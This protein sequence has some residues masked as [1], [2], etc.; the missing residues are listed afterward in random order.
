MG[1]N[2][3]PTLA[4][5]GE[6]E[7]N[8][9]MAKV[10]E[11]LKYLK[12]EAALVTSAYGKNEQ[13]VDSLTDANKVLARAED[14]Q[15]EAV[16]AAEDALERMR[17]NGVEP[18]TTAYKRMQANINTAKAA[19]NE[20]QREIRNNADAMEVLRT[21]TNDAT[22]GVDKFQNAQDKDKVNKYGGAVGNLAEIFGI[23]IPSGIT[24]SMDKLTGFDGA[25]DTT[26]GNATSGFG[27]IVGAIG[28]MEPA[29]LGAIGAVAGIGVAVAKMT[30]E[31]ELEIDR[32]N[33]KI[34]TALG[35]TDEEA[36]AAS[37]SIE[38]IYAGFTE[39][40]DEAEQA[41]TAVMRVMQVSGSEAESY[42]AQVANIK[43]AWG[44]DYTET[45]L[46]A[47]T[48]TK[49]FGITGQEAL[50]LIA[51]GLRTTADK[52]GDL[53]DVLN[54]YSPSFA[55]L[56]DDANTFLT[57]IIAGTDAGAFSADKAADA[58]K[59]I[60]NKAAEGNADFMEAV[61]S[62][63]LS[64]KVMVRDLTSGDERAQKAIELVMGRLDNVKDKT[65]QN[66]IASKLLGTQWE[67]VGTSAVLAM[68][69]VSGAL[70]DTTDAS[71]KAIETMIDNTSAFWG[72]FWKKFKEDIGG[73]LLGPFLGAA[74]SFDETIRSL[75]GMPKYANGT[76]YHPGG[77][78]IVGEEGPE[79]VRMPRGS[80]VSPTG[81]GDVYVT[82]DAKNVR[83]FNDIVRIVQNARQ[84][85]RAGR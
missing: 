20:T 12:A 28:G 37:D 67:D 69:D 56:G 82:V 52:N 60:F 39:N 35:L 71:T 53:L 54:E 66:Q 33:A 79:V 10:R 5:N 23:K 41:L 1:F 61:D 26:T 40:R 18:T 44:K 7:Y 59:E 78:A 13:S 6:K 74:D 2:I 55:R 22:A 8:A 50:D 49:T 58:Y 4:V 68:S 73:T 77:Y 46:A 83:E 81:F 47:S 76:S 24:N 14:A 64:S 80:A 70:V 72:R 57:R 75:F 11:N 63:G 85:G 51:T 36:A 32:L 62:L 9:A 38:N 30:I 84:N 15:R 42:A 43:N 34:Q 29:A 17:E 3:G 16:K 65:K 31:A 27:N 45:V 19:L 21:Q 25:V 48:L